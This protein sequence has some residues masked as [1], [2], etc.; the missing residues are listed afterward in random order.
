M[1]QLWERRAG[2]P[3]PEYTAGWAQGVNKIAYRY[4][5][6]GSG[7]ERKNTPEAYCAE[8]WVTSV[9]GTQAYWRDWPA[10][11]VPVLHAWLTPYLEATSTAQGMELQA[12]VPLPTSPITE[13]AR[14]KKNEQVELALIMPAFDSDLADLF[15]AGEPAWGPALL[16][17]L[18]ER[19]HHVSQLH[20]VLRDLKPENVMYRD[21]PGQHRELKLI[22][23]DGEWTSYVPDLSP[24]CCLFVM[25]VQFEANL[26]QRFKMSGFEGSIRQ[27]AQAHPHCAQAL[28]DGT[29]GKKEERKQKRGLGDFWWWEVN[30]AF[31]E[32]AS[33]SVKGAHGALVWVAEK[34]R[35]LKGA[36]ELINLNQH[37]A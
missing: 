18:Y 26:L 8:A 10:P 32:H 31:A 11:G 16:A 6:L 37:Q 7:S 22:D 30:R 17:K 14:Y 36:G 29:T 27:L 20:L 28:A 24:K 4:P 1:I 33:P 13:F 9:L 3:E 5:N 2:Q 34:T 15:E 25:L 19:L 23:F 35:A 12:P 21:L